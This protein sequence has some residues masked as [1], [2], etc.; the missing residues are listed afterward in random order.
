MFEGTTEFLFGRFDRAVKLCRASQTVLQ[1][2][3]GVWWERDTANMI[4]L[5]A[6]IYA[7]RIREFSEQLALIENDAALRG[8]LYGRL[9]T[10]FRR[11]F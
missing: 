5:W 6:L 10:V 7:G 2:E 3:P 1:R 11:S 4:G 9:A 8:S